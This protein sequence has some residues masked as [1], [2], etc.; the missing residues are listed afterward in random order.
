MYFDKIKKN[1]KYVHLDLFYVIEHSDIQYT[2]RKMI[3]IKIQIFCQKSAKNRTQGSE[4]FGL[5]HN[6]F[7]LPLDFWVIL[8]SCSGSFIDWFKK[9]LLSI[10]YFDVYGQGIC[11]SKHLNNNN[12]S[13]LQ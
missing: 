10:K 11:S 2:Y 9:G 8:N 5:V 3:K 13:L 12:N 7:R 1:A 4:R 6:F